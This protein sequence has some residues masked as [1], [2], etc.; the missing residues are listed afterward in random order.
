MCSCENAGILH[1]SFQIPKL[2]QTNTGNVD[3][4]GRVRDRDFRIRP[5]EGRDERK[6]EVEETVV[7]GEKWK[8]FGGSRELLVAG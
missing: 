5:F 8:E 6:D 2:R 4:I 3:N 7:E 1:M